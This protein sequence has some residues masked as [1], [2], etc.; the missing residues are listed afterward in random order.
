MF[1][2]R[3]WLG[4]SCSDCGPSLEVDG[5]NIIFDTEQLPPLGVKMLFEAT[6][7]RLTTKVISG[8]LLL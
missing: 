8:N 2:V 3:L 6:R 4:Y 7:A 5:L 1:L